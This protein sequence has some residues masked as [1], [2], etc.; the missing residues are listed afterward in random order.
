MRFHSYL[1]ILLRMILSS[2][3]DKKYWYQSLLDCET[4]HGD[5]FVV[6]VVSPAQDKLLNCI[7]NIRWHLLHVLVSETSPHP[8]T[9]YHLDCLSHASDAIYRL[10]LAFCFSLFQF[11]F[12]H[13]S[14]PRIYEVNLFAINYLTAQF[15]VCE[16][17][18]GYVCEWATIVRCM[19]HSQNKLWLFFISTHLMC[20]P[21]CL[22]LI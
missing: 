18:C 13:S 16:C 14:R 12:P 20:H 8:H 5:T 19:F 3:R 21:V 2:S 7:G 22:I 4:L 10:H 17:G 6:V 9:W 11:F 1:F 15:F